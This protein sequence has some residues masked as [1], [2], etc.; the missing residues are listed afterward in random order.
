MLVM[1]REDKA[2]SAVTD[3]PK[4]AG[5]QKSARWTPV[6]RQSTAIRKEES[7]RPNYRPKE[8]QTGARR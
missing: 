2:M 8:T 6:K 3:M 1:F 7:A 5:H 4:D